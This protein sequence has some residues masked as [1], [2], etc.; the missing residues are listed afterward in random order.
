MDRSASQ[1]RWA[2]FLLA[3]TGLIGVFSPSFS[4]RAQSF[5]YLFS[6]A[7]T[8]RLTQDEVRIVCA[9]EGNSHEVFLTKMQV[10]SATLYSELRFFGEAG[11]TSRA[12]SRVQDNETV[13]ARL[14]SFASN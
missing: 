9:E 1:W 3:L 12:Q 7:A 5:D 2:A 4:A 8:H 14:A 10:G 11:A 6:D 13:A